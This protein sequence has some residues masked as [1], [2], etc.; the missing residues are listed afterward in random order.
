MQSTVLLKIK[1][2]ENSFTIIENDIG[3]FVLENPEYVISNTI[4]NLAKKTNTSEASINRFS[5]KIGF[6]GFNKFKISLAQSLNSLKED[7]DPSDE[8]NLLHFLTHDYK[9]MLT[10]TS[11]MISSQDIDDAASLIAQIRKINILAVYNTSFVSM[12]FAFKLRQLGIDVTILTENL[13][14]QLAIENMT[15]DSILIAVV[16]SITS[17]DIIPFLS[18][19][20]RKNVKTILISSN[21]NPKA[22][23][24]IDIKFIIPDHVSAK[25][26]LVMTNSIMISLVFDVLFATL[27]RDNKGLR[28]KKLNSDTIVNS[29]Q[30][31]DSTIYEW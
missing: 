5:K 29:Y 19:I 4:T 27:L 30:S 28:Q 17:R 25:N 1:S 18:K 12:E 16:P 11:A 8:S 10:S 22:T 24:L 2:L 7:S 31:A 13:Q 9:S 3:Q 6:K 20:K 15:G 23:D 26:S 14:T 21:D